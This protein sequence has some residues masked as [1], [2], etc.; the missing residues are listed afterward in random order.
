[1]LLV[2]VLGSV[3]FRA[4][5][6]LWRRLGWPDGGMFRGSEELH[7]KAVWGSCTWWD[8]EV[9]ASRFLVVAV[10]GAA[11]VLVLSRLVELLALR[12]GFVALLTSAAAVVLVGVLFVLVFAAA[13]PSPVP[14]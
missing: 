9:A 12:G 8:C 11:V 1:M 2:R 13:L 3:R 7:L 4:V 5:A 6:R 10:G 14:L